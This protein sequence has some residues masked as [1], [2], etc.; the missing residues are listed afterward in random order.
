GTAVFDFFV[1]C[2]GFWFV[3]VRLR[4]KD[5]FPKGSKDKQSDTEITFIVPVNDVKYNKCSVLSR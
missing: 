5:S 4:H 2:T 1:L 3:T